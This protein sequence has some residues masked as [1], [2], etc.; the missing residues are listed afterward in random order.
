MFFSPILDRTRKKPHP[1]PD[2]ENQFSE[3]F[4]F[5]FYRNS[6]Q[7]LTYLEPPRPPH[8][9][10]LP[11][12]SLRTRLSP[13]E[14]GVRI[15]FGWFLEIWAFSTRPPFWKKKEFSLKT[16]CCP[17][18]TEILRPPSPT[19]SLGIFEDNNNNS[20]ND[21]LDPLFGDFVDSDHGCFF[22]RHPFT[23]QNWSSPL[24]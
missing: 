24:S 3:C 23:P 19:I 8:K 18:A 12:L 14:T 10:T 16:R 20:H 4:Y 2:D 6:N 13:S 1:P 22:T 17:P 5:Y 21:P 11:S 7:P 15:S 9:P